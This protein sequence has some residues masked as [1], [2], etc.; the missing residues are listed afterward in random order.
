MVIFLY[1]ILFEDKHF[2][3]VVCADTLQILS[4]TAL[5]FHKAAFR[6]SQYV[7]NCDYIFTFSFTFIRIPSY[8]QFHRALFHSMYSSALHHNQNLKNY[9]GQ[10]FVQGDV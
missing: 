4:V 6:L 8:S 7:S 2:L 3:I 5:Y 9:A 10:S 1:V